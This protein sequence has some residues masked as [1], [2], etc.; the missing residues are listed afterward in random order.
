MLQDPEKRKVMRE[1]GLIVPAVIV[2]TMDPVVLPATNANVMDTRPTIV[3]QKLVSSAE[4]LGIS[5]TNVRS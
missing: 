3:R 4:T 1:T 2:I 5:G